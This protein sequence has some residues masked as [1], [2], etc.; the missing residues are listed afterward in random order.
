VW[1]ALALGFAGLRPSG[2]AL[3]VDPVLPETWSA[4]EVSVRFRDVPVRLR[5]EPD[6]IVANSSAA[7][8][9]LVD[10]RRILCDAGETI[11]ERRNRKE[12]A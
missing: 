10:G 11:V 1:Q 9:L 7:I 2:D 4:L 3:R 8:A 6:R 12:T 5:V